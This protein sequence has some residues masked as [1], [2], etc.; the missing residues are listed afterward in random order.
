LVPVSS[1]KL[2]AATLPHPT[3]LAGLYLSLI[4]MEWA[5]VVYVWRAGLRPAGAS[6][7][8]LVGGRWGSARAVAIDLSLA[9][10][11]WAVWTALSWGID[12]L[13]ARGHAA[14][15]SAMLPHQVLDIALW[16]AL[17]VS[18]GFAEELLFRGYFP[19]AVPRVHTGV[20]RSRSCSRRS[21]SGSRT[22]TRGRGHASR[23]P[24]MVCSWAYWR[25]LEAA[26]APE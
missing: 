23:S 1:R 16:I 10:G 8:D 15:V 19:G 26:F 25:K 17:S 12:R 6:L 18:A 5:L 20:H 11:T 3:H 22:A 9:L 13:L 14:S 21:C 24:C 4:A 2:R 7:R